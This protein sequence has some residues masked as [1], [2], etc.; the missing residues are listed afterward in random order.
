MRSFIRAV[1]FKSCKN[2]A[3][4]SSSQLSLFCSRVHMVLN[5]ELVLKWQ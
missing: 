3:R 5:V 2:K 1:S 4:I